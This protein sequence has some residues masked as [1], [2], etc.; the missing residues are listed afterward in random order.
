[1]Q[2][3]V[4]LKLDDFFGVLKNVKKLDKIVKKENIKVN[5]G[6]VGRFFVNI[7][8][9]DLLWC[10]NAYESGLYNFWNH[11]FT[12]ELGEFK[13]LTLSEQLKHICDTQDVVNNRLG[14]IL[15]TFGAPCNAY[16]D[17]TSKALESV[18]DIRYWYYGDK[19]FS[20][21]NFEYDIMMEIPLFKPNYSKFKSNF[22][23]HKKEIF[24]LQAHPNA[25]N[26]WDFYNFKKIVRFLKKQNCIFV[27]P[28]DIYEINNEC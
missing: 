25:W 2:K 21:I 19:N 20:G 18:S 1:M 22:N 17:L 7:S 8:D 27:F 12:H 4:I 14:I 3:K 23:N 6:I 24:V 13:N 10:K 11:G 28:E 9:K 5:W 16:N 26:F 15:K